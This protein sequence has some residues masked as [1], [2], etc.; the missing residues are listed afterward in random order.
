MSF[1][2]ADRSQWALA[3][4]LARAGEELADEP[5]LSFAL[6]DRKLS[7]GEV[8]AAARAVA[9]G[10]AALGT[11]PGDRILVML[12]NRVEFAVAWLGAATLGAVQVPVNVDYRGSFLEHL[13]QTSGAE[14]LIVEHELLDAVE[15]SLPRLPQLRSIAVVGELRGFG[16]RVR[17]VAFEEL[18]AAGSAAIHF[19]S[20]TSGPSKGAVLPNAALHL[21]RAQPRA[22]RDRARRH[23]PHRAAALPR[24]HADEHLHG[25]AR[26]SASS[27]ASRRAPGSSGRVRAAPRTRRC[28][29]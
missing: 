14:V 12:R 29:A 4:L 27:G 13:V 6:G 15:A 17:A 2:V 11:G 3:G 21:L 7:F 18:L 16:P 22:A 8:A 24:Q 9:G 1:V 25:A 19:T 28:S 10:L 20:G 5:Y 23:L 26:R